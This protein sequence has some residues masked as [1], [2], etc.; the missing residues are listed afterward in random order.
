MESWE[1][2]HTELQV[3]IQNIFTEI[4]LHCTRVDI[5][6]YIFAVTYNLELNLA[7][8]IFE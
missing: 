1:N 3:R 8:Q 4:Q 7:R 6:E 5:S 2:I